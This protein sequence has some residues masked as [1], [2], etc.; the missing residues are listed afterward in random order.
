MNPRRARTLAAVAV[1]LVSGLAAAGVLGGSADVP[2]RVRSSLANYLDT[3]KLGVEERGSLDA[4]GGWSEVKQNLC[5]RLL[6]RLRSAAA[7]P[8]AEWRVHAGPVDEAVRSPDLFQDRLV[9]V[10]G[11]A[12]FVAPVNLPPDQAELHSRSSF[13]LVRIVAA[14]GMIV[15]VITDSA[16][17]AWKRWAAIDERSGRGRRGRATSLST[18]RRDPRR[19]RCRRRRAAASSWT[20]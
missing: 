8:A 14:D 7:V 5:L 1:A 20:A 16:P 4:G 10:D 6:A 2:V 3:F 17:K 12:V 13:D 19:R 18:A 9:R 15:D 11:R